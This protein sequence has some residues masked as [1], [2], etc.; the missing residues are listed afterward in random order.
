MGNVLCEGIYSQ[1]KIT[2]FI[3]EG[4]NSGLDRNGLKLAD[5]NSDKKFAVKCLER[6]IDKLSNKESERNFIEV[7]VN[8]EEMKAKGYKR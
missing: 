6:F 1:R 2:F 4:F 7:E 8:L 5:P 3:P